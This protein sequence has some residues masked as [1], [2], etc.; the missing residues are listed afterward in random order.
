MTTVAAGA[1]GTLFHGEEKVG[2]LGRGREGLALAVPRAGSTV[3]G[4]IA[5]GIAVL[6]GGL[7]FHVPPPGALVVPIDQ[8]EGW[9]GGGMARCGAVVYL[10]LFSSRFFL[11]WTR[12]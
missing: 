3:G 10:S 8:F 2:V 4:A 11:L 1:V 12:D 9:H 5:N 7:V 6:V